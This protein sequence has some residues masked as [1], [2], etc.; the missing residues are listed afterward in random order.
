MISPISKV[1]IELCIVIDCNGNRITIAKYCI[2]DV[3]NARN[4]IN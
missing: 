4:S 1:V 3:A 2:V